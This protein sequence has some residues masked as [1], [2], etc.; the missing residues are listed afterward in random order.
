MEIAQ[1]YPSV[2]NLVVEV[3]DWISG[4]QKL[5]SNSDIE[6]KGLNNLVSYVDK[7]AEQQLVS[8]LKLILPGS[9]FLTEEDTIGNGSSIHWMVLPIFCTA[10][11]CIV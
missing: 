2:Q 5:F 6:E 11:L 7:T 9:H 3:G 4:Q 10:Y 8:G 1:I